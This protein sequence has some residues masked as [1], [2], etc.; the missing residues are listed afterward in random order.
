MQSYTRA[1]E[2]P[3]EHEGTAVATAELYRVRTAQCIF[4]ADVTK[5]ASFSPPWSSFEPT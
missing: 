5:P 1:N 3:P 2:V 4:H